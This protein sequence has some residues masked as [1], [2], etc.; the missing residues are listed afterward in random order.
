MKIFGICFLYT[1]TIA[2]AVAL[3]YTII[4][5]AVKHAIEAAR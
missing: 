5:L 4:Y 3:E 1:T 2:T